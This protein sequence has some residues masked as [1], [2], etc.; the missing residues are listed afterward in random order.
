LILYRNGDDMHLIVKSSIVITGVPAKS[1]RLPTEWIQPNTIVVNVASYKN[2]DEATLLLIPGV[3]YIPQVGKVTVAMLE[4]NVMR[5]FDQFHH[6]NVICKRQQN[7]RRQFNKNINHHYLQNYVKYDEDDEI[8][9]DKNDIVQ[10]LSWYDTMMKHGTF[11]LTIYTAATVTA[12]LSI[13]VRKQNH[14]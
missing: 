10:P 7:Y 2:V 8:K 1:Y 14:K 9:D 13:H 12:L 6:P 4:R 3:I 5:L 11:I